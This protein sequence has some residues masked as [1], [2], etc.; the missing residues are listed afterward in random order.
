LIFAIFWI[1]KGVPFAG[2]G[3]IVGLIVLSFSFLLL[4]V[5]ILGQYISLIY[6]EVK[7]RPIYIISERTDDKIMD[8]KN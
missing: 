1:F 7:D 4:S 6:E 2:F 5:G 3:T 8:T